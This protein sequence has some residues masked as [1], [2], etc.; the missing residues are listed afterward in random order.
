MTEAL[1]FL[2]GLLA[3]ASAGWLAASAAARRAAAAARAE[4]DR[5]RAE[6]A[7]ARRLEAAAA[8][9]A[10][11]KDKA[12]ALQR[13]TAE[14][15]RKELE[16]SFQALAGQALKSNTDHL[17]SAAGQ[18]FAPFDEQLKQLKR[19]T[20]ELENKRQHAYGSL[21]E[22]LAALRS[23]TTELKSQSDRLAT[24]LRGS[25][26]ARGRWGEAT[27]RRLA[28]LAGMVERCDFEEQVTTAGGQRPDLVVRLPGTG[29]I[30]VDAKVPLA[31]YLDAESA[32]DEEARAQLL[33]QHA[34]ALKGH[35][36]ELARRDYAKELGG[37]VDFTVLFVPGEPFLAAAFRSD[38]DLFEWALGQKILIASPV[39]LLA[40]LRTVRMNWEHMAVEEN[41]RAIRDAAL[42]LADAARVFYQHF[43]KVGAGLERAVAS[44]NEAARSYE[45]RLAPRARRLAELGLGEADA[46]PE[47]QSVTPPKSLEAGAE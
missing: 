17:L 25:S 33:A 12:I 35:V 15:L 30:P 11:E 26:Q 27:L 34:A 2:A 37:Q 31:A 29:A 40:L 6:T 41:A 38:P 13:Q 9:R 20:E 19:A 21:Q 23:S 28:E 44:F 14:A 47:V 10:E 32:A 43:G 16:T 4:L 8:A 42:K 18:K 46:L 3:G 1:F 36:R 45:S 7:E 39:N 5:A 22:Q 24:A